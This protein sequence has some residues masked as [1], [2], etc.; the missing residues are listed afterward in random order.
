M[1]LEHKKYEIIQ[2]IILTKQEDFIYAVE[3]VVKRFTK[4]K[5]QLNLSKH[6]NIEPTVNLEKIKAERPPIDFDMKAF[7]AEADEL[8]WEQSIEELL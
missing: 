6:Q 3:E 4:P 8:E 7:E 1:T 5:F 2:E